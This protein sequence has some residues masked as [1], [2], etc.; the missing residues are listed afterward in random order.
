MSL[1]D[2][3]DE[4]RRYDTKTV[5]TMID[6]H[7]I[8]VLR[9]LTKEQKTAEV[10]LAA[11]KQNGSGLE[12]IEADLQTQDLCLVAVKRN[13]TALQYVAADLQTREICLAAVRQW[14]FALQH[15]R[16]HTPE[17]C[18]AAVAQDKEALICVNPRSEDCVYAAFDAFPRDVPLLTQLHELDEELE[19]CWTQP[20]LDQVLPEVQGS[21]QE[22]LSVARRYL[23]RKVDIAKRR[24][25][26]AKGM[27]VQTICNDVV[28]LLLQYDEAYYTI[29][30]YRESYY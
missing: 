21:K 9:H 18:F 7:P 13:A 6:G 16:T 24:W 19:Y 1:Q 10:C 15:V 23:R 8:W 28:D 17:L 20:V 12:F 11:V 26:A 2:Q 30:L 27:L 25:F 22:Y 29:E 3:L 14:P 4:L 5:M